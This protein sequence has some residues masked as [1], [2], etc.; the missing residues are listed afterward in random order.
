MFPIYF[1]TGDVSNKLMSA[2][3]ITHLKMK[4]KLIALVGNMKHTVR[5]FHFPGIITKN[6]SLLF[7]FTLVLGDYKQVWTSPAR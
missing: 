3:Y 6:E 1:D 4:V 2:C 7:I 5:F